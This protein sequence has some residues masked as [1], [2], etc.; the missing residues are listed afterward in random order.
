[1]FEVYSPDGRLSSL[2]K[3]RTLFSC[4]GNC[5][6]TGR[7]Q[8]SPCEVKLCVWY[9]PRDWER[10]QQTLGFLRICTWRR[11]APSAN[12]N[13]YSTGEKWPTFTEQTRSKGSAKV[14][15]KKNAARLGLGLFRL[16]LINELQIIKGSIPDIKERRVTTNDLAALA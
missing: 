3:R 13:I 5:K 10:C 11:M 14:S 9:K 4:C 8:F 6:E 16:I 15:R 7:I 12:A 2:M 1:M